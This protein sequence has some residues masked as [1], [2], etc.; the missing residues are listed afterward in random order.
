MRDITVLVT[1]SGAPGTA[2]LVR[3]LRTNGERGVRVVGTDM[4][5]QAVGRQF[6]D[7]FYVVP[8]G[9]DPA[10]ADAVLDIVRRENVD[11]VLPQSSFDLLGLAEA[12]ERFMAT[13]ALVS[14]PDA[15]RKANDKA[16]AAALLERIGL[17]A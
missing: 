14:P 1:A 10:F 17:R 15:I 2:A 11:A 3:A 9:R 8:P 4:S 5:P 7:R 6:C 13:T 16:E 12:R